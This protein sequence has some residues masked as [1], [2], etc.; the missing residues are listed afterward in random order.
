MSN[1]ESEIAKS[2]LKVIEESNNPKENKTTCNCRI[3]TLCPI[4]SKCLSKSVIYKATITYNN[5]KLHFTGRNF[6]SRYNEHKHSFRNK[7][8]KQ[9]TKLS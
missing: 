2:N 8:L 7:D 1:I 4:D 6:K 5:K 3:K 9:S